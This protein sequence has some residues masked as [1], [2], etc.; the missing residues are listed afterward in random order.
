MRMRMLGPMRVE[1]TGHQVQIGAPKHRALLATL[2]LQRGNVMSPSALAEILWDGSLPNSWQTTLRNYIRRVRTALADDA[3][4][5]RTHRPGYSLE[6]ARR[7]LDV[8]AF[9]DAVAAGR[10]AAWA[11]DWETASRLLSEALALWHGT[12]LVDVTSGQLRQ[13]HVPYLEDMRLS[14]QAKRVEADLRISGDR[15][16]DLV[17][18]LRRLSRDNPADERFRGQ[19]MIALCLSGRIGEALAAYHEAWRYAKEEF[20][21]A[22]GD[23]LQRLHQRILAGEKDLWA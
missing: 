16:P 12:P 8:F 19:L 4:L 18:D 7:D 5:L 6:I 10:S 21:T 23:S 2:A 11:R 17:P 20:G 3:R 1:V 9:E 15:A 14:A 22:T 13:K